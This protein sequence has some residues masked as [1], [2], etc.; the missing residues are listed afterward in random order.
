M[1]RVGDAMPGGHRDARGEDLPGPEKGL[2]I[3]PPRPL[4]RL[5]YI[6]HARDS[7]PHARSRGNTTNAQG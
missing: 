2:S 7:V 4:P 6:S 5:L 3:Y 1:G